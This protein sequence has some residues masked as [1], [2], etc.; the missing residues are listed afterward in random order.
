MHGRQELVFVAKMVLAELAGRVTHSLERSR[1]RD[2]LCRN[3][4]G[5]AGLTY[6]C[7]AGADGKL[8]G[9]EVCA[10]CRATRLRIVVSEH[11]ALGGQF[12]EVW[13]PTCHHAAVVG[14]EIP[15]TDV[16]AHD[17][18]DVRTLSGLRSCRLLRLRSLRRRCCSNGRGGGECCA[19]EQN[20]A[21]AKIVFLSLVVF[22]THYFYSIC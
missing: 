7:H 1:N 22:R 14:A 20:I 17:D 12:V 8:A 11:H 21:P 10:S 5:C 3:A 9:D 4:G 19:G 13:R 18:D 2:R 15:H 16:V 6:G